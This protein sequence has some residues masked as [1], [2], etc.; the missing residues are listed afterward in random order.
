MN[1]ILEEKLSIVSPVAQTTRNQ[2]RGIHTEDRGQ[3]VF[4]D[5]PGLHTEFSKLGKIMNTAAK[6]SISGSDAVLYVMDGSVEPQQ[7]DSDWMSRLA[8][9]D[10]PL[11]FAVNKSDYQQ[12]YY[13]EYE[14]LWATFAKENKPHWVRTSAMLGTGVTD[15]VDQ[16]FK[17][18]PKG[19]LL[20]PKD[21]LTDFPRKLIISDIIREKFFNVLFDE[22]PHS[23]AVWV[24]NIKENSTSWDIQVIV[25]V[26]SP[27]QKGIV[28]GRKGRL[29]R[30]VKEEASKD[31]TDIYDKAAN[32]D[33]T[34]KVDKDWQKNFWILRNLGYA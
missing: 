19:P 4:L 33:I 3:I 34:V 26:K 17:H 30:G 24:E 16:L 31:I 13:Q 28:I 23:I 6:K 25:Y 8:E 10:M 7:K 12:F 18:V 2:I 32:L 11:V 5:T 14:E 1:Y 20:F 21:M 9:F 22:V 15:L 27:S 29:L